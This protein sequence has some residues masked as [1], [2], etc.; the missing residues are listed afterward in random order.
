[1][2]E[3]SEVELLQTFVDRVAELR[4]QMVTFNGSSFDLPSVI[5]RGST[6]SRRRVL[7]IEGNV[8]DVPLP[9]ASIDAVVS[10]HVPDAEESGCRSFSCFEDRWPIG[11]HRWIANQPLAAADAQL[12]W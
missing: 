1:M 8:M 3:R 6:G 11:I 7:S 5:E 12:M 9:D 2:G 4:P 10:R